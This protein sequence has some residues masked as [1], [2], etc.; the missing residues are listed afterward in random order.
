MNN[1]SACR[2]SQRAFGEQDISKKLGRTARRNAGALST[3]IA[4]LSCAKWVERHARGQI[5]LQPQ[6]NSQ[7]RR[8]N[9]NLGVQC[10]RQL[11]RQDFGFYFSGDAEDVITTSGID[12][13][14]GIETTEPY[15]LIPG[16]M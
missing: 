7:S 9:R 2:G 13:G 15:E 1:L 8:R 12:P 4:N 5:V 16:N 10:A 3:D 14:G 11:C 6:G